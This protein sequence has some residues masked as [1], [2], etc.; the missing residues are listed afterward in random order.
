MLLTATTSVAQPSAHPPSSAHSKFS[1]SDCIALALKHNKTIQSAYLERIAQRFDLRV[2]E[3]K[4][5]PRL[6][7][8]PSLTRSQGATGDPT[9]IKSA[10]SLTTSVEQDSTI[11]TRFSLSAGQTFNSGQNG[12]DGRQQGWTLGV[13]Q[14]LLKGAGHDA[15]TASV[16]LARMTEQIHVWALQSTLTNTLV[17][18]AR[19]YRQY[20]RALRS[21]DI[22][23]QSL[24]RA[25]ELL[26]INRT[27]IQA[28]RMA[29]I[30]LIQSESDLA[31]QEFS[32][33]AAEND[34]DAA[35]L[36]LL[37]LMGLDEG[38]PLVPDDSLS[39][40]R[41]TYELEEALATARGNRPDFLTTELNVTL[42]DTRLALARNQRLPDLSLVA[43]FGQSRTA[44]KGANSLV[45]PDTWSLGVRLNVPFNDLRLDQAVVA[46]EVERDKA[47]I[48]FVQEQ[49]NLV[50][51]VRNALRQSEMSWRQIDLSQRALA[52]AQ[53][54]F[55]VETEKFKAGRSSNF[56]LVSFRNELANAQNSALNATI[57]YLD[58]ITTL[59]AVL[60]I[61]LNNWQITLV[62]H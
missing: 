15:A 17:D 57:A 62:A 50:L 34:A 28:G 55:E 45:N 30:D 47:K 1:L 22:N 10:A 38:T 36:S 6:S 31:N 49:E 32:L 43:S 4:F 18:V 24:T 20:V 58:A 7:V 5:T 26:S 59:E 60:G 42:T 53:R 11:G 44:V 21:L 8:G 41:S 37:K 29:E 56:Q 51:E 52:L 48:R 19:S 14:P 40:T 39:A 54:K 27:L 23:R 33:L 25:R 16:R 13:V 35:R 12:I 2:A 61:V 3:S 46:A 9:T